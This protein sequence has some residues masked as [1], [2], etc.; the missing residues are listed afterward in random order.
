MPYNSPLRLEEL[1]KWRFSAAVIARPGRCPRQAAPISA[2]FLLCFYALF[3]CW[4]SCCGLEVLGKCCPIYW[5][6]RMSVQHCHLVKK[7]A[8]GA[9]I[10]GMTGRKPNFHLAPVAG[11]V[12]YYTVI[13]RRS[14]Q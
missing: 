2:H 13:I 6:G 11:F 1:F 7:A 10:C 5:T 4:E 12:A 9:E 14:P 3:R 8:A